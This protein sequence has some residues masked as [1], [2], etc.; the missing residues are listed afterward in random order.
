[1]LFNSVH[2]LI[3]APLVILV[4]FSL[5]GKWQRIWL[6]I[7][8]LYFYAVFRVPFIILLLYAIGWTYISVLLMARAESQRMKQLALFMAVAGNLS[9]LYFFKYIDFSFRAYNA[10]LGLD[11][12][13]FWY[14]HSPGIILP[15]GISF[16]CLQA[17]S[18]AI[19]VYRGVIP[20]SRNPFHFALY[21]SFFPQLVAGPIIRAKDMLHQFAER[22]VFLSENF[23]AGLLQITIGIFKKTLIA[24]PL[25]HAVD[26]VFAEPGAYNSVSIFLVAY[27]FS[28]QIYCDFSG[29]SDIAIG[30]ARIMGFHIPE[31]FRRPFLSLTMGEFWRRWHISLSSWL[32]DYVYIPLGGNRCSVTRGYIN[33]FITVFLSGLWHGADWNYIFW[34][35]I[36][37]F[38]IGGEKLAFGFARIQSAFDKIP[39]ILKPVYPVSV[40]AL[41]MIF[42][43]A[44]PLPEQG[45]DS[46]L[47]TAFYMLK[48]ALTFQS[49]DTMT[50]AWP[51]LFLVAVLFGLDFVMDRT[52]RNESNVIENPYLI[53]ILGGAVI[54]TAFLIYSVS[55]SQQFIYFQF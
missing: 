20:P 46:A 29:Y 15:M 28:V 55:V 53:Y 54:L 2:F 36:H 34:G 48:H 27:I 25:S 18:Y 13:S 12:S 7:V 10:F 17:I 49:G 26:E 16:Y 30:T 19:D 41:S 24:D 50:V 5:P 14:A 44:R 31:N 9:L 51:I 45:F 39:G 32:R 40:F 42:F 21:L 23:R 33:I 6:F 52:D 22:K 11:P 37:A 47:D 3:F 4:F 1:M 8:S 35:S 38:F 43:R